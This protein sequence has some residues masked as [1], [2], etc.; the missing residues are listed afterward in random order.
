[1]FL[2]SCRLFQLEVIRENREEESVA[3][4]MSEKK[5]LVQTPIVVLYICLT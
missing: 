4:D 5:Q 2:A 3:V 1:V